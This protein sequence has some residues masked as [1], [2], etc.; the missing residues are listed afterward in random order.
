VKFTVS[1]VAFKLLKFAVVLM[2]EVKDSSK[3]N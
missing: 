2:S 1:I 3:A